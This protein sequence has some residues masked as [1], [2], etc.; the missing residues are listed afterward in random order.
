MRTLIEILLRYQV[1]SF[2]EVERKF[3]G[4]EKLAVD[5]KSEKSDQRSNF[6]GQDQA[7]LFLD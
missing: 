2:R 6:V 4:V 3:R 7:P 1:I 5:L